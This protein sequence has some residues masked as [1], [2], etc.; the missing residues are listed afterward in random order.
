MSSA[1][2]LDVVDMLGRLVYTYEFSQRGT[3][4]SIAIPTGDFPAGVYMLKVTNERSSITKSFVK[5][6]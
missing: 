5:T 3:S 4:Q 2:S 1:H 6:D